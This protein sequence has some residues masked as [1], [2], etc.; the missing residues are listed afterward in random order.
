MYYENK[1]LLNFCL[2]LRIFILHKDPRSATLIPR[3][4]KTCEIGARNSLIGLA[5][6]KKIKS[7]G[8]QLCDSS[9]GNPVPNR[10]VGS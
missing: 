8:A 4:S 1:F 6:E 2:R 7:T 10:M 3:L 5:T 9:N